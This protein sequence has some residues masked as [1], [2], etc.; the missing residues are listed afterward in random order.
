[1]HL[2]S[3]EKEC[4]FWYNLAMKNIEVL[5]LNHSYLSNRNYT[6]FQ[7]ILPLDCE[8]K[9][10]SSDPVY[11]FLEVMEG[12]NWNKYLN[13][14][15]HRG[16][17]EYNPFK[18]IKV[19]LFAFMNHIYSLRDIEKSCRTDI[20]FM[21]LMQEETPSHMAFHRFIQKYLKYDIQFIFRDIFE[22]IEILDPSIDHDTVYIDGTKLEANAN[23]FTFI[24]KKTAI[25]TRDKIFTRLNEWVKKLGDRI[26]ASQ[27]EEWTIK[28]I[29][30]MA[31]QIFHI[32][33]QEGITFI[34]GKGKRKSQIQRYYDELMKYKETLKNCLERIEL[35]GPDRN[36]CSKT[37]HDATMMHMKEDHYMKTGIFK[38]GYNAQIAVSSEYIQLACIYQDRT[39]QKTFI[40]FLETFRALYNRMPKTVVAD[41]GYGSYDNYFFCLENDMEAYIKYMMYSK[42]KETSYKKKTFIKS[43]W[44]RNGNG[45]YICPAGHEFGCIN[46]TVDK[47]SA[48]YRINQTHSCGKCTDCPLKSQCTKAKGDRTIS[49]NPILEEFERT[50]REKLNSEEGI[51]HRVQRSIQSEGAFGVIKEDYAYD[52]LH[53]RSIKNVEMEFLLVC[54]GFNLM[55]YHNKK[56]R[57]KAQA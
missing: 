10:D 53:R 3:K 34:Y 15:A 28:D 44:D 6:A 50:A 42:E 16:R 45:R 5:E 26:K 36:S 7:M 55:K 20:R 56:I 9:I 39:D 33:K 11:S 27:K 18:M 54:V 21:F 19:I 46:E 1:M 47:R 17:E 24:W 12:V 30:N 43:N 48:Y 32:V 35:C 38:A 41:A 14:P 23:K 22:S 13:H 57:K 49:V 31:N 2:I 37:D 8:K 40:K 51:R 25:K 4:I 52:R 29:E